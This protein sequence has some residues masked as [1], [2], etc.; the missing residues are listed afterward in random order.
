M[1]PELKIQQLRYVIAVVDKGG[2]HAAAKFLH[3][4]QPALS[5][6]VR[7]L[8]KTL[9]HALFEH[10]GKSVLTPFGEYCVP[11]FRD[12]VGQHDR[13]ALDLAAQ[14]GYREG[15]I[16]IATVPSV[17]SRVM[18]S[19]LAAFITAYPNLN[20][21]LHDENAEFVCRMVSQGEV[22][23]GITSLWQATEGLEYV[24]LFEDKIGVVCRRDHELAAY[25]S[26]GWQSVRD[27]LKRH[28]RS[29]PGE[30][31]RLIRNGTSRLLGHTDA[32]ALVE[33]SDFYISNMIS[34]IA[35][36]EAG[37]GITTLPRLAFP[38][39]T[40]NLCFIPLH[41]PDVVRR[42]G[43]VKPAKRS[44]S[45]AAQALER[46]IIERFQTASVPLSQGSN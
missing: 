9:E 27:M 22:D 26:L 33:E 40:S 45:P 18:P 6:G 35:M 7:E 8:E 13:I 17:A 16:D 15:R 36:L 43:L 3:R 30:P 41:D 24:H 28:Q 12:L 19:L 20:I 21:S 23:I 4:T 42:I 34:L 44:L 25:D 31:Q 38:E 5:M 11:R 10:G 2:F 37:A 14:A 1:R 29:S 46:F 32:R 39:N